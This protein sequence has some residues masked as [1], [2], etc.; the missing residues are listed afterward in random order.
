MA[1]VVGLIASIAT[2]IEATGKTGRTISRI[3]KLQTSP[4]RYILAAHNEIERFMTALGLIHEILDDGRTSPSGKAEVE[5]SR[6]H[7]QAASVLE[8]FDKFLQEKVLSDKHN[9]DDTLKLRRR[10][11][12]KELVGEAQ[13][14]FLEFQ[15]QLM[16]IKQNMQLVLQT[17]Q[18]Q[19]QKGGALHLQRISIIQ[20]GVTTIVNAENHSVTTI[21]LEKAVLSS[22]TEATTVASSRQH[23]RDPGDTIVNK[24]CLIFDVQ[25][26]IQSCQQ[27][28]PCQ[29]HIALRG[30][31][32][33]WLRGLIGSLFFPSSIGESA[34]RELV[35]GKEQGRDRCASSI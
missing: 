13:S 17:L 31:T 19:S 29:C 30:K 28:C 15:Q 6:L 4:P 24:D 7:S 1:E 11:I 22:T 2:L 26:A 34:I 18:F 14:E 25:Q 5:L 20:N 32:P 21:H 27:W 9:D 35:V 12:L 23:Q 3:R 8:D 33:R 16:S 10:A